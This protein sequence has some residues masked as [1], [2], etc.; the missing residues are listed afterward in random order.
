MKYDNNQDD[1][2]DGRRRWS[3]S[4]NHLCVMVLSFSNNSALIA[5]IC[6]WGRGGLAP[7]SD[8]F[9]LCLPDIDE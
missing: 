5:A 1:N 4:T 3:F 7:L 8:D 6:R 2:N 9:V